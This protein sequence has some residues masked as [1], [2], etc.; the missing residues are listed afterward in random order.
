MSSTNRRPVMGPLTLCLMNYQARCDTYTQGDPPGHGQAIEAYC[1]WS[2]GV[3]A[4]D[5]YELRGLTKTCSIR[6]QTLLYE[7]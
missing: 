1:C 7:T 5:H 3:R 6:R 4:S 2:V